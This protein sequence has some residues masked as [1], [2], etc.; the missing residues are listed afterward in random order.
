MTPTAEEQV[1]EI[2]EIIK[3]IDAIDYG[4]LGFG[5]RDEINKSKAN[6]RECKIWLKEALEILNR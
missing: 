6:L 1:E 3:K 2:K 4:W 5:I